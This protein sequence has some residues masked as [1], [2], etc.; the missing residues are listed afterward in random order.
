MYRLDITNEQFYTTL[1]EIWLHESHPNAP[2]TCSEPGGKQWQHSIRGWR[3]LEQPT[4]AW[5]AIFHKY[6][7]CIKLRDIITN[8]TPWN[9][10]YLTDIGYVTDM[11]K[12][13]GYMEHEFYVQKQITSLP[14]CSGPPLPQSARSATFVKIG[15][16]VL[17]RSVAHIVKILHVFTAVVASILY[18]TERYIVQ[19]KIESSS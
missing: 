3:N 10:R 18:S 4:A 12:Y 15:N 2:S 9:R 7:C 17:H 16:E 8:L 6:F 5:I 11:L 19:S 13:H 14:V 1:N